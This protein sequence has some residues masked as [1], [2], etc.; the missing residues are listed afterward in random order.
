MPSSQNTV[1]FA[2][3]QMAQAGP[4]TARKMFGEYAIYHAEKLV[5]LI[6]DDQLYIKPT[7]SGRAHIGTPIE[8]PPY[9]GAKPC[10]LIQADQ[11]DNATWLAT[12]IRLTASELPAPKPKKRPLPKP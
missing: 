5:A 8:A 1:D 3:E 4:V 2:L 11:W 9:P 12:L 6:T 10:F 7:R